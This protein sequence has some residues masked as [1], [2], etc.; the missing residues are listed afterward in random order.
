MF[1]R[2]PVRRLGCTEPL[3][4]P[5]PAYDAYELRRAV[6]RDS[7]EAS[8]YELLGRKPWARR[9]HAR[10]WAAFRSQLWSHPSPAYV[11]RRPTLPYA[12]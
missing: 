4:A 3:K 8:A 1:T 11:V 5:R 6:R 7:G 9:S 12:G 10:L 2:S